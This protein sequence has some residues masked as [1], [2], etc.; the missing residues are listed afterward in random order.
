MDGKTYASVPFSRTGAV[1]D[2]GTV[3]VPVIVGSE[4]TVAFDFGGEAVTLRDA[5]VVRVTE[6]F[7]K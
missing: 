6:R 7:A 5:S 1:G 3:Y 2:V 4:T